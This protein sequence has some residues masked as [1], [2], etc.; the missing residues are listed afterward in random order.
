MLDKEDNLEVPLQSISNLTINNFDKGDSILNRNNLRKSKIWKDNEE[1]PPNFNNN[2]NN[3]N[4]SNN[5]VNQGTSP[6]QQGNDKNFKEE[7]NSRELL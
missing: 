7:K 2:S 5:Q 6:P 4:L 1:T 3:G